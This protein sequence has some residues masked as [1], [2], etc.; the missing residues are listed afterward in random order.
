[1]SSLDILHE[2]FDLCTFSAGKK[3]KNGYYRLKTKIRTLPDNQAAMA[4]PIH[5]ALAHLIALNIEEFASTA[6]G[7]SSP[8][9]QES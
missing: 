4:Q 9:L 2:I 8:I 6:R 1:L 7:H 5:E 3:R